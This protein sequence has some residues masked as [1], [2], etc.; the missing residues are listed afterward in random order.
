MTELAQPNRDAMHSTVKLLSAMAHPAR[1]T[2]L[3]LLDEAGKLSAG[4]LQ[5]V[6]GLEQSAMS[7]QL[8]V[9]REARLVT[10]QRHGKCVIYQ[11]A[12]HHVAHIVKDAFRHAVETET[13]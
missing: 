7:H 12:D 2:V 9:L 1:L 3:L 11:L 10:S 13:T 8:K 6:A 5:K 4:E